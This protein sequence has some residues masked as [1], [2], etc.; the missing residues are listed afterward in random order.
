MTSFLKTK[1]RSAVGDKPNAMYC[2]KQM[3]SVPP[4]SRIPHLE[5]EDAR[6]SVWALLCKL[7]ALLL[8]HR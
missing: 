8:S 5:N 1:V 4:G 6:L 2:A 7:G 3:V